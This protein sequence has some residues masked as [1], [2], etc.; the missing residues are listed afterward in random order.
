MIT[1][2]IM[3]LLQQLRLLEHLS[4][5]EESMEHGAWGMEHGGEVIL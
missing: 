5:E 2:I 1:W 4:E 3:A